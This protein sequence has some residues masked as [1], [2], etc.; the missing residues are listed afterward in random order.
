M[1]KTKKSKKKIFL[2]ILF[3]VLAGLLYVFVGYELVCKFTGN[4]VYLFG[5]RFDVVLTDSMSERNPEHAEFLEGTNQIQPFDLVCS[6]KINKDTE[7]NVKDIVLFRNPN[8][9]NE[10]VMHR[11]VD[12]IEKGDVVTFS[13]VESKEINGQVGISLFDY[14]S[15]IFTSSLD[16]KSSTITFLSSKPYNSNFLLE[17]GTTYEEPTSNSSIKINDNLYEHKMVFTR[18]SY[19]PVKLAI[20]PTITEI[21]A[22]VTSWEIYCDTITDIVVKGEDYVPTTE[23][24]NH[25]LY[26]NYFIYEIRGD[27][28]RTSDGLFTQDSLISKVNNV[29]PKLGYVVRF[30]TSIPGVILIIGLAV[31]FSVCGYLINKNK[32][33]AN[34]SKKIN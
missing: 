29:I 4:N 32:D 28:A 17:I 12:K 24:S 14:S 5:T 26:N 27:K 25:K 3:Y 8:M 22:Y 30:L 16:V 18:S 20:H 15:E 23:K 6:S 2:N 13:N 9:N 1:N 31:I 7:L 19:H 34:S 21:D 10:T 11:I 33:K